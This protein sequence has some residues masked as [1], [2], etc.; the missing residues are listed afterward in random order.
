[1]AV[2]LA[3]VAITAGANLLGGLLGNQA[4]SSQASAQRAFEER[5]SSTA[6]QRG[7]ADMRAAGINPM[8]AI[9]Q[10][11]AS[12]PGGAMAGVPNPNVLGSSVGS[13]LDAARTVKE[14]TLLAEQTRKA[15]NEADKIQAEGLGVQWDNMVKSATFRPLRPGQVAGPDDLLATALR[16]AQL[17]QL[18]SSA[19]AAAAAAA[20]DRAAL[21]GAVVTGGKGAAWLRLLLQAL[22]GGVGAARAAKPAGGGITI[23]R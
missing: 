21:P 20:L 19:G 16:R 13:A 2:P 6:W 15:R 9:S 18:R 23:N 8:L 3:P 10:G 5:M 7:V 11:P 22:G 14:Y 12:T 17:E 1:M 4:A